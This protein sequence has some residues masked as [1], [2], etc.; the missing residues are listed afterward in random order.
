MPPAKPSPTMLSA[1]ATLF[2]RNETF[3]ST[4][5]RMGKTFAVHQLTDHRSIRFNPAIFPI[6][7]QEEIPMK[8]TA[9]Q[10][11]RITMNNA[12]AMS[13]AKNDQH[14]RLIEILQTRNAVLTDDNTKLDAAGKRVAAQ[15]EDRDNQIKALRQDIETFKLEALQITTELAEMRGYIARTLEDDAVREAG[16]TMKPEPAPPCDISNRNGPDVYVPQLRRTGPSAMHPLVISG[17]DMAGNEDRA[18]WY[19]SGQIRS[20]GNAQAVRHWLNR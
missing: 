16:A 15:I 20:S 17:V 18:N 8:A 14:T 10:R 19:R 9:I 5:L 2:P 4:G 1:L 12:L 13:K 11:L 6:V 3:I 7:H